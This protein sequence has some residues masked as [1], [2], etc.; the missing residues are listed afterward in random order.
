MM[1]KEKIEED[2]DRLRVVHSD[3][4]SI[5]CDSKFVR[6]VNG[7]YSL[8]NGKVINRESVIK[9]FGTGNATSIFAVTDEGKILLVVLPRV[10][11]PTDTKVNIELP[12]GYI[13]E[14]E[15]SIDAAKRELEEETG[16]VTNKIFQVD[17]YYPSLG[18][19]GERI[20][21]YLALDCVK[22]TYQHLDLDEFLVCECVTKEE[23]EYL[24]N[25]SYLMGIDAR[26]GYY[27]YL[28]YL[29]KGLL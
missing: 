22:S 29:K 14:G 9:N 23:F 7:V 6:L 25:H 3:E 11:L 12:A 15:E 16:Y 19:S 17:S 28:E 4:H 27:H 5:F 13:E 10:A 1:I 20:D 2:I 26:I 21:L 18:V 24:L 8:N